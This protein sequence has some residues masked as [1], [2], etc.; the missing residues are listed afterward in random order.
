MTRRPAALSSQPKYD[1][2]MS[3]KKKA[4]EKEAETKAEVNDGETVD[5]TTEEASA[6]AV[7]V[8]AD[9]LQSVSDAVNAKVQADRSFRGLSQPTKVDRELIAANQELKKLLKG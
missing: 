7:S 3:K 6:E 2:I 4:E 1:T 9:V 5:T 8:P